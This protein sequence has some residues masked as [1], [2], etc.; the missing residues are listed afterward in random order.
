MQLHFGSYVICAGNFN[1]I[2]PAGSGNPR[3]SYDKED[4]DTASPA[5]LS[6]L[7]MAQFSTLWAGQNE[8]DNVMKSLESRSMTTD[9]I[10]AIMWWF[11]ENP[12]AMLIVAALLSKIWVYSVWVQFVVWWHWYQI[13]KIGVW[14]QFVS[15]SAGI[16]HSQGLKVDHCLRLYVITKSHDTCLR[17]LLILLLAYHYII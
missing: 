16:L 13:G 3:A 5:H 1:D 8:V 9:F 15:P 12:V 11:M 14:D 17:V 7:T 6:V 4:K 10:A 2:H